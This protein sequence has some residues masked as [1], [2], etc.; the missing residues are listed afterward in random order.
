CQ[1]N[2]VILFTLCKT[3]AV[4]PWFH[5]KAAASQYIHANALDHQLNFTGKPEFRMFK[6][7]LDN[8]L[9]R[10]FIKILRKAKTTPDWFLFL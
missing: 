6:T 5:A 3:S 8:S 4:T 1:N 10:S 7:K 9:S 2:W